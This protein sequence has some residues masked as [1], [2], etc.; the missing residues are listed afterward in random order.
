ME[1]IYVGVGCNERLKGKTDGSMSLVYTGFRGEL[2]HLKIGTRLIDESFQSDLFVL[3]P[4]RET[5]RGPFQ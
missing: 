5:Q 2:E 1:Y 3:L 4:T